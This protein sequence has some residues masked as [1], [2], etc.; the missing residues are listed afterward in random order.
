MKIKSY[1]L[2]NDKIIVKYTDRSE[3]VFDLNQTNL[4]SLISR[5]DNENNITTDD[6]NQINDLSNSLIRKLGFGVIVEFI[7]LCTLFA[8][9]INGTYIGFILSIGMLITWLSFIFKISITELKDL[10]G[11]IRTEHIYEG[12]MVLI[13]TYNSLSSV[14]STT[15]LI[16]VS[17]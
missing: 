4:K 13:S 17:L 16:D 11:S 10:L 14:T 3:K 8:S 5:L 12:R 15:N 9:F 2:T 7:I 6:Y 1:Y